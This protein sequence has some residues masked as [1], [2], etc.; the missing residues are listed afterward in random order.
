[1]G[2]I[3]KV[4]G[5]FELDGVW[6]VPRPNFTG[7]I[8][9]DDNGNFVGYCNEHYD[10]NWPDINKVR[11]LYGYIQHND[12]EDGYSIHM[13][14][15]SNY[16]YQRPLLYRTDNNNRSEGCTWSTLRVDIFLAA[17]KV[18]GEA[19]LEIEE[20]PYLEA[21]YQRIRMRFRELDTKNIHTN[22]HA[23]EAF[24]KP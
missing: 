5:N 20:E 4:T 6:A 2:K 10:N 12:K 16:I 24:G 23:I 22:R 14:K 9:V 15:L 18:R 17:F 11:Y 13:L 1:M 3:L 19:D 8:A 21:E 7:K